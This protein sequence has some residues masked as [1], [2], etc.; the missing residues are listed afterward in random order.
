MCSQH[1][2]LVESGPIK[3]DMEIADSEIAAGYTSKQFKLYGLI[4]I[5]PT[6]C[7]LEMSYEYLDNN[8]SMACWIE[9]WAIKY[10]WSF[11]FLPQLWPES[12]DDQSAALCYAP[13]AFTGALGLRGGGRDWLKPG[14]APG[15]WVDPDHRVGIFS[16][17]GTAL[18]SADRFQT[19]V[20]WKLNCTPVI[21]KK[22]SQRSFDYTSPLTIKTSKGKDENRIRF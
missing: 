3:T 19:I 11:T 17:P 20:G 8:L 22:Y 4:T 14:A 5:W 18:M 10:C 12:R 13:P 6:T 9:N 2:L 1:N 7:F 16:Q 21:H 15:F